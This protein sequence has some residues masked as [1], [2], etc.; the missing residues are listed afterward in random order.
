VL[1]TPFITFY[2]ESIYTAQTSNDASAVKEFNDI[3]SVKNS[4]MMYS[5]LY[6]PP[7]V[8]FQKYETVSTCA[9]PA[10]LSMASLNSSCNDPQEDATMTFTPNLEDVTRPVLSP[11]KITHEP[12]RRMVVMI[13]TARPCSLTPSNETEAV[14]NLPSPP[15]KKLCLVTEPYQESSVPNS[16]QQICEKTCHT[17][18]YNSLVYQPNN[19][20][21]HDIKKN[22]PN[23][24]LASSFVPPTTPL[25]FKKQKFPTQRQLHDEDKMNRPW[26]SKKKKV[27]LKHQED[28]SLE[29]QE[30]QTTSTS[31]V[32]SSYS[33]YSDATKTLS[34][35]AHDLRVMW[36]PQENAWVV[37]VAKEFSSLGCPIFCSFPVSRY[38]ADMARYL[39]FRWKNQHDSVVLEQRLVPHPS[40][41]TNHQ[42]CDPTKSTTHCENTQEKKSCPP[43]PAN[44]TLPCKSASPQQR[45]TSRSSKYTSNSTRATT[46]CHSRNPPKSEIPGVYWYRNRNG[47]VAQWFEKG[48]NK[49]KFFAASA[50]GIEGAKEK[51]IAYRL[52]KLEEK[53]LKGW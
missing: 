37:A 1:V 27:S 9:T 19:T 40:T 14:K 22:E 15:C 18:F 20:T 11:V 2:V 12:K 13:C 53:R 28:A 47:W 52:M 24:F 25:G 5:S 35:P 41:V 10:R 33:A 23:P 32:F 31:D 38:G 36:N 4:M 44:H 17:T 39:A 16:L 8:S 48:K 21:F 45:S 43:S 46:T 50:F 29:L 34:P 51:A 49:H 42:A 6:D 3:P 7:L 30:L 26:V